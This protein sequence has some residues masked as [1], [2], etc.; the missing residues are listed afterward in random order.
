MSFYRVLLL[1]G[2]LLG[3]IGWA[4]PYHVLQVSKPII[5]EVQLFFV[6]VYALAHFIFEFYKKK[7]ER[8]E[9]FYFVGVL[10]LKL[11]ALF[12]C[13]LYV[14][15]HQIRENHSLVWLFVICYFIYLALYAWHMIRLLNNRSK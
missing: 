1:M 13:F 11:L 10:I 15:K 6:A 8:N 14:G 2:F 4:I 7:L 3:A 5:L 9:G 12:I